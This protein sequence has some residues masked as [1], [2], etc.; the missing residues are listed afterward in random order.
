[1]Y[2][3]MFYVNFDHGLTIFRDLLNAVKAREK[4][5]LGNTGNDFKIYI[6]LSWIFRIYSYRIEGLSITCLCFLTYS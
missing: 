4:V 2:M 6:V 3:F 5:F 1:M